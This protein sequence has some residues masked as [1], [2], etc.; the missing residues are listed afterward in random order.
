MI[1][2]STCQRC[3]EGRI[4]LKGA[5]GSKFIVGE[6]DRCGATFVTMVR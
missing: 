4:M 5:I 3:K 6:C 2:K 1:N